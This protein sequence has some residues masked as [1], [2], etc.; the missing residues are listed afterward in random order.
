MNKI[1]LVLAILM[2]FFGASASAQ[3]QPPPSVCELYNGLA[4][5][6][7][8]DAFP[9]SAS[10]NQTIVVF[11]TS[12]T[13]INASKF[14]IWFNGELLNWTNGGL[15]SAKLKQGDTEIGEY[16]STNI[17]QI[18]LMN[19]TSAPGIPPLHL[20]I[21]LNKSATLNMV[22]VNLTVDAPEYYLSPPNIFKSSMFTINYLAINTSIP[23]TLM[24]TFDN[25]TKTFGPAEG[26]A[27]T[28]DKGYYAQHCMGV[29]DAGACVG[30]K[31]FL[32]PNKC[33]VHGV[34]FYFGNQAPPFDCQI[35]VTQSI[36]AYDFI[37][38]NMSEVINVTPGTPAQIN[39]IKPVASAMP[40]TYILASNPTGNIFED[41]N[42]SSLDVYEYGTNNK[43]FRLAAFKA[44]RIECRHSCSKENSII[45]ASTFLASALLI[46]L[47]CFRSPERQDLQL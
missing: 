17:T 28:D 5:A 35:N 3:P 30:D 2:L 26:P 9:D 22:Q 42:I 14:N 21:T 46:I 23:N 41:A 6:C 24:I 31:P 20:E 10:G 47:S 4:A 45:L 12:G 34:R 16:N 39:L 44:R 29:V 13:D 18:L 8:A 25:T 32:G 19:N 7:L 15:I 43:V 33:G 37:S 40:K 38:S 36:Y 11:A 1:V 27:M